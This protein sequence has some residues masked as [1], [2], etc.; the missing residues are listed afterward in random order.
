[1]TEAAAP[2]GPKRARLDI[3]KFPAAHREMLP[4]VLMHPARAALERYHHSPAAFTIRIDANHVDATVRFAPADPRTVL[5]MERPR[6]VEHAAIVMAG[7]LLTKFHRK[8]ITRVLRRGERVD[9]YVG[10]NPGEVTEILEVGGTDEGGIDALREKKHAQLGASP[11]RRAP[12]YK[13][14]FVAVT[15][16]APEAVSVLDAVESE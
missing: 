2:S 9:Y 10:K 4:D 8:A 5:T 13:D 7:V 6:I 16:F 11:L 14:G 3:E 15:R 1:V 12:H